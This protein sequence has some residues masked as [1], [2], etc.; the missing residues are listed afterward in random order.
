MKSE[1]KPESTWEENLINR[2]KPVDD[3]ERNMR[4]MEEIRE[5]NREDNEKSEKS[6]RKTGST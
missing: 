1:R 4:T 3:N 6:M 5:D 2:R